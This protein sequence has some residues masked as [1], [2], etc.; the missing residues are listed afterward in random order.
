ML[1]DSLLELGTR[2]K[3]SRCVKGF[4]LLDS[5]TWEDDGVILFFPLWIMLL[6][7]Q[8]YSSSLL[9]IHFYSWEGKNQCVSRW[10]KLAFCIHKTVI[11]RT[12][13]CSHCNVLHF[14]LQL[15]LMPD[16]LLDSLL[17]SFSGHQE[18]TLWVS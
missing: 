11:F 17:V 5:R 10:K 4:F 9:V 3:H 18:N 6:F 8:Y 14:G 7:L 12:K 16:I 15:M 13:R 1:F 2:L